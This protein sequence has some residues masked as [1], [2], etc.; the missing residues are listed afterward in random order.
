MGVIQC[1]LL[2]LPVHTGCVLDMNKCLQTPFCDL[3]IDIA[4]HFA[5]IV[6]L[7]WLCLVSHHND[8]LWFVFVSG[9]RLMTLSWS[10][11]LSRCVCSTSPHLPSHNEGKC[12][13]LGFGFKP[14][15]QTLNTQ[16]PTPNNS[17]AEKTLKLILV[18]LANCLWR[19][20][21]LHSRNGDF[22]FVLRRWNHLNYRIN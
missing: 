14:N 18:N 7:L 6:S 5:A 3:P 9:C 21:S 22:D 13:V 11:V 8:I 2:L 12:F 16:L 4:L 10:H 1:L 20:W 19:F 15:P 17:L